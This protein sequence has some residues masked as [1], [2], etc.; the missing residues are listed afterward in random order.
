MERLY[1]TAALNRSLFGQSQTMRESRFLRDIK[2]DVKLGIEI[3]GREM[4]NKKQ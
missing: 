3:E 1:L 4:Y 2:R